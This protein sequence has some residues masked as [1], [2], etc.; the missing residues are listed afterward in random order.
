M[1]LKTITLEFKSFCKLFYYCTVNMNVLEQLSDEISIFDIL[2]QYRIKTLKDKDIEKI[3]DIRIYDFGIFKGLNTDLVFVTFK[4]KPLHLNRLE[5]VFNPSD[6]SFRRYKTEF[7]KSERKLLFKL[8]NNDAYEYNHRDC[9]SNAMQL[10]L[11]GEMVFSSFE[12]TYENSKQTFESEYE[13]KSRKKR[14]KWAEIKRKKELRSTAI[15]ALRLWVKL[16]MPKLPK[17]E[18]KNKQNPVE[19]LRKE[20]NWNR[21]QKREL[22]GLLYVDIYGNLDK[23]LTV[24]PIKVPQRFKENKTVFISTEKIEEKK[25]RALW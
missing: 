16:Q 25:K 9:I 2:N 11:N 7:T 4:I 23:N 24:A 5:T 6:R 3:K 10:N 8:K 15:K 13:F 20:K 17:V 18:R 12:K 21:Y 1:N 22:L 19:K 14:E